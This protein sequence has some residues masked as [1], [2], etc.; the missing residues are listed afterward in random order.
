MLLVEKKNVGKKPLSHVGPSLWSNLNKTLKTLTSLNAFQHNV[1][2][3][4]FNELKKK[5]SK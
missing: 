4:Y 5:G 1:K 3:H 2:Q